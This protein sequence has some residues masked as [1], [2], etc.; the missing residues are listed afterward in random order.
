MRSLDLP[1]DRDRRLDER[2][3]RGRTVPIAMPQHDKHA[4]RHCFGQLKKTYFRV[5]LIHRQQ[6]R[7]REAQ[8]RRDHR[9]H[10]PVVVGAKD[11]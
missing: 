6:R 4:R 3:H 10:R 5:G 7:E 1:R 11:N 9:L 2:S 8:A